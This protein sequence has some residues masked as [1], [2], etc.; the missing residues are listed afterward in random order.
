[1]HYE[2]VLARRGIESRVFDGGQCTVAGLM[3]LQ[4]LGEAP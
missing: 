1:M 4:T 2:R 3:R